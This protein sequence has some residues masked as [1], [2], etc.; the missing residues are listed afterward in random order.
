MLSKSSAQV[1]YRMPFISFLTRSVNVREKEVRALF[2]SFAYF[3]CLLTAYYILRLLRDEMS[4][5][6]GTRNLHWLLTGNLP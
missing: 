3:F 6:G 4:I 1:E 2:W 5:V